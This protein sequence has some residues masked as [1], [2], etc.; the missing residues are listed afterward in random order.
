MLRDSRDIIGNSAPEADGSDPRL[1]DTIET[2]RGCLADDGTVTLVL[3]AESQ[4]VA[5]GR[6]EFGLFLRG[7]FTF[8]YGFV[9]T[10]HITGNIQINFNDQN[11]ATVVSYVL[12]NHFKPNGRKLTTLARYEDIV[13]R[14]GAEW[15]ITQ[16]V[17]HVLAFWVTDGWFPANPFDPELNP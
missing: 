17:V 3:G 1:E 14:I 2:L 8:N 6:E 4:L 16:R 9:A 13:E 7:F 11:S 15:K 12:A 10:Q 5:T